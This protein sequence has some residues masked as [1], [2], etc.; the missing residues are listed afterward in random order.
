MEYD[1]FMKKSDLID[2]LSRRFPGYSATNAQVSVECLLQG[3]T[4]ALSAGRRIEV[5]GF[6]SFTIAY[7]RPKVGR[8]PRTGEP[9]SVPAKASPHFKAGKDLRR[10]VAGKAIQHSLMKR[11][12]LE[13][14]IAQI[15]PDTRFKEFDWG[16][17]V[18][19]EIM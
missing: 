18:G 14:L 13:D 9:V 11:Y 19:R 8:N 2:R 6:G 16:T 15:P 1:F 12:R 7:H 5:R 17:P 4:A 3:I 10:S